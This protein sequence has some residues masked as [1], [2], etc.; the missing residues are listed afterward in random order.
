[1]LTNL[2]F[3]Q[4]RWMMRGFCIAGLGVCG[5]IDCLGLRI[6]NGQLRV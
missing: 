5:V 3:Y 4:G 1:M 6:F 2:D